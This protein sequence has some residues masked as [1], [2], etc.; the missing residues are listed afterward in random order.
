MTRYLRLYGAF[1]A[2]QWRTMLAY[3]TN[4]LIGAASTIAMQSGAL[5]TIWVVM[6]QIPSLHGWTLHEVLLLYGLINLALSFGHMFADNLWT[7]GREYIQPGGFDRFLVRPIN[8]LFHLLADRF[9]YDGIGD[10]IV[11]AAVTAVA[12]SGLDIAWTPAKVFYLALAVVSGGLIFIALNMITSTSAFWITDSVPVTLAVF[13]THQFA[14]YPLPIYARWIR[15]L[16]T[17]IIPYGLVSFYPASELTG[18]DPGLMAW[19]PPLMAL[20]LIVV[21]Y[22][23]WMF[24]LRHYT[25]TGS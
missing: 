4:F 17:W 25:G 23:F 21:G 11:G 22:R 12:V 20:V 5:L 3:R 18:H 15:V 19:I 16:M 2:L 14:R 6:R 1:L 10:F 7:V 9:C 24:G 13:Q 8:P